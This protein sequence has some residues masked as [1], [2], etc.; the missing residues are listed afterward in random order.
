MDIE[1]EIKNVKERNKR[2][3][4]DKAWETSW[5]R[6][7]VIAVFTYIVALIWLI[8]IENTDPW[9][10]AFIPAGAYIL[11]TPSLSFIKKRWIRSRNS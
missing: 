8:V 1:Q 2:V 6:R 4:N 3:E 10:N 11:S 9:L 5:T 7:F